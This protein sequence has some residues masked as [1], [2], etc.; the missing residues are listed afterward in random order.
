[1]LTQLEGM[2]EFLS[3]TDRDA[4][5]SDAFP[6]PLDPLQGELI[7]RALCSLLDG[8]AMSYGGEGSD[9]HLRFSLISH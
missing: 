8:E 4:Y 3:L 2:Y 7:N 9:L 5:A 6:P 1:M